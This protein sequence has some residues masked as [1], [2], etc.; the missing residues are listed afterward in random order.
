VAPAQELIEEL[1]AREVAERQALQH[2]ESALA[3]LTEASLVAARRRELEA[4]AHFS[5][6]R[7]A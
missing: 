6:S 3:S 4:L 1:G 5:A 2:A 7:S